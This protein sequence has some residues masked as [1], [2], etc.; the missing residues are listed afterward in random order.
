MGFDVSRP[1]ELA[2]KLG[3][4]DVGLPAEDEFSA[5]LVWMERCTFVQKLRQS[6]RRESFGLGNGGRNWWWAPFEL[7]RIN[8]EP[9]IRRNA[10]EAGGRNW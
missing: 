10:R 8:M 9:T 6:K 5:L 7:T 3:Q 2:D 4:I 1:D